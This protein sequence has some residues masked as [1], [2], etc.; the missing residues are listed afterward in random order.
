MTF[1]CWIGPEFSRQV[2]VKLTLIHQ[3]G[4]HKIG[5]CAQ[6]CVSVWHIFNW[7]LRGGPNVLASLTHVPHSGCRRE[8]QMFVNHFLC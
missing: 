1:L 4:I 3:D 8:F 5:F 6:I 2:G 7:C